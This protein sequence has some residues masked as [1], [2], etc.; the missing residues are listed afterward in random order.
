MED[1]QNVTDPNFNWVTA[2]S[3]CSALGM[4]LSLQKDLTKDVET[5]NKVFANSRRKFGFSKDATSLTVYE[6]RISPH[7]VAFV[8]D[9]TNTRISVEENGEL[10]YTASF[11]LDKEGRCRFIV[12]DEELENW[13]FRKKALES[14]FFPR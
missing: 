12:G 8:L 2:R 5:A 9:N 4:F 3:E 13:Q 10:R 11:T 1:A 6:E 7:I 14:L